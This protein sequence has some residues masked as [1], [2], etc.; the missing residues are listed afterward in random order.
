MLSYIHFI[1]NPPIGIVPP[2]SGTN[3]GNDQND[4]NYNIMLSYVQHF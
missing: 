1:V 4:E 2:S 3:S